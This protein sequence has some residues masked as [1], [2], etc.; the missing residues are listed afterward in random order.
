MPSKRNVSYHAYNAASPMNNRKLA[1][2]DCLLPVWRRGLVF[3]MG[4]WTRV[5]TSGGELPRWMDTKSFPGWLSQRQWDSVTRQ[6]KGALD[7]WMELRETEFRRVVNGSSLSPDMK[8]ELYDI[9]RRHE[10]WKPEDDEAH[11]MARRIIKHLRERV[12]FPDM[13]RCRTM[14]MDGKIARVG[15]PVNAFHFQYWAVVSTLDK[16]HPVR[17][18]L[19]VDPRMNENTLHGDEQAAN[20]L[21]AR[22]NRDGSIDLHL[23]TVKAKARKRSSGMVIGMDWGLKSLFATSQ[24]QLHGLK[25][26]TWL[27]QRDKELTALTRAL[28]KSGIRYR[29]SRRYRNLNKRIRDY[30]RNEVNR[31]LNLLSRQEIREIVVEELDFRNGGLSKKMNRIISRAGRNAVKAKLKDLED[32]KGITVT[33]VNPAYTSQECPSCGYVNPRNRPTQE[34]F[35]CTCCGYRSQ[36]DIN[37]S[38]NILARRSREDGWRR[39]GRRQ[40]LAM[41]LREHD[42]RFHPTGGHAAKSAAT[43]RVVS[44]TPRVKVTSGRKYH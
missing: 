32:N 34:H 29:Q 5:L 23:M 4:G 27:Q 20:H 44:T 2:F 16:G 11:R 28:A 10:W 25:L 30:T 9:N 38:H 1:E 24:G 26:Y 33:K 37:A 17:I 12:P 3:A 15:T 8:R 7:S 40:I 35:R 41:L 21:Q 18:P 36:A 22:I 43:P 31:I 6:A 13:R 19:T 39:I 42:E 14:S